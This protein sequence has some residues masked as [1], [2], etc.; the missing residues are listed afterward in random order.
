MYMISEGLLVVASLLKTR[1]SQLRDL[2]VDARACC[3]GIVNTFVA[4]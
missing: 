2:Y 4:D 3:N 1:G